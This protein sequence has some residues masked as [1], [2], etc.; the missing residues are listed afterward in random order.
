MNSFLLIILISL[1]SVVIGININLNNKKSSGGNNKID[2]NKLCL[3]KFGE[4][5]YFD[6][7]ENKCKKSSNEEDEEDV[8]EEDQEEPSEGKE[9][10]EDNEEIDQVDEETN[11]FTC[12]GSEDC[13]YQG[14]CID[15]ACVCDTNYTGVDCNIN[16]C[17]G[18]DCV[19][20]YCENG[21]C[22]CF[23]GWNTKMD[24]NDNYEKCTVDVCQNN[25]CGQEDEIKRGNC[26]RAENGRCLCLD[27][28]YG[29]F[30]ENNSCKKLIKNSDNTFTVEDKCLNNSYC[31]PNT[32]TCKCNV[33]IQD[34]QVQ[35]NDQGELIKDTSTFFS[36]PRCKQNLCLVNKNGEMVNK[37]NNGTC[38]IYGDCTCNFGYVDKDG[39][40]C[41]E[42]KCPNCQNG[43]CVKRIINNKVRYMCDCDEGWIKDQQGECTINN[44]L[45]EENGSYVL[46][47]LTSEKYKSKCDRQSSECILDSNKSFVKCECKENYAKSNPD[48]NECDICEGSIQKDS[49][50]NCSVIDCSSGYGEQKYYFDQVT[51]LC[52]ANICA[53]PENCKTA[54]VGTD[55]LYP[56]NSNTAEQCKYNECNDGYNWNYKVCYDENMNI[57]DCSSDSKDSEKFGVCLENKCNCQNGVGASGSECPINGMTKCVSCNSGFYKKYS[58]ETKLQE[59]DFYCD[60]CVDIA[61]VIDGD[62]CKNCNSHGCTSGR[63]SC[64]N[65]GCQCQDKYDGSFCELCKGELEGADCDL[66]KCMPNHSDFLNCTRNNDEATC[67]TDSNYD[68]ECVCNCENN[69]FCDKKTGRCICDS[70]SYFEGMQCEIDQCNESHSEYHDCVNGTCEVDPTNG[71]ASC[72]C[73][74]TNFYGSKCERPIDAN[75]IQDCLDSNYK[76]SQSC[77]N[78]L[79]ESGRINLCKNKGR[80]FVKNKE[81]N[82]YYCELPIKKPVL[83]IVENN[84]NNVLIKISINNSLNFY[85]PSSAEFNIDNLNYE[86]LELNTEHFQTDLSIENFSNN[87]AND[88]ECFYPCGYNNADFCFEKNGLAKKEDSARLCNKNNEIF[89]ACGN[90][91][92]SPKKRAKT[93]ISYECLNKLWNR[94]GCAGVYISSSS[95]T[96]FKNNVSKKNITE[97]I[98]S[99]K[100]IRYNGECGEQGL[101]SDSS[102]DVV[103]IDTT[104]QPL[105]PTVNIVNRISNCNSGERCK[106]IKLSNLKP[107]NK[108]SFRIKYSTKY[109]NYES[110]FSDLLVFRT[111]CRLDIGKANE[112]C[113]NKCNGGMCGPNLY[114]PNV[115]ED[116]RDIS[117]DYGWPYYKRHLQTEDKCGCYEFDVNEKKLLCNRISRNNLYKNFLYHD[118]DCR[119]I[120]SDSECRDDRTGLDD[121]YDRLFVKISDKNEKYTKCTVE[122]NLP[123]K[124]NDRGGIWIESLKSPEIPRPCFKKINRPTI[125]KIDIK[126]KKCILYVEINDLPVPNLLEQFKF[127]YYILVSNT[128][129]IVIGDI[130]KAILANYSDISNESPDPQNKYF[131]L[132]I[133]SLNPRTSYSVK[134]KLYNLA[135]NAYESDY[136]YFTNFVTLCDGDKNYAKCKALN[137]PLLVD[138]PNNIQS[139]IGSKWPFFKI[140]SDDMCDCVNFTDDQRRDYCEGNLAVNEEPNYDQKKFPGFGSYKFFDFKCMKVKTI[141]DCIEESNEKYKQYFENTS[142][143]A[144]ESV[145]KEECQEH[146]NN[147]NTVMNIN[148]NIEINKPPGCIKINNDIYWNSRG[149]QAGTGV[150]S[151]ENKCIQKKLSDIY[152]SLFPMIPDEST[153]ETS[154]RE[155]TRNEKETICNA[156]DDRI[157]WID[158]NNVQNYKCRHTIPQPGLVEVSISHDKAVFLLDISINDNSVNDIDVFYNLYQANNNPIGLKMI[159]SEQISDY[160]QPEVNTE[161]FSNDIKYIQFTIDNLEQLTDYKIEAFVETNISNYNSTVSEKISFT[162]L[163]DADSFTNLS[164]KSTYGPPLSGNN[165]LTVYVNPQD[166]D[167]S[168]SKW[169]YHKINSNLCDCKQYNDEERVELCKNNLT[170]NNQNKFDYIKV[171]V[172]DSNL[173]KLTESECR[174]FHELPNG[175]REKLFLTTSSYDSN[176]GGSNGNPN[177]EAGCVLLDNNLYYN[178]VA[179]SDVSCDSSN[180]FC[181]KK[182]TKKSYLID[183]D[184][185]KSD[186]GLCQNKIVKVG[187]IKNFIVTSLFTNQDVETNPNGTFKQLLN[188]QNKMNTPYRILIKWDI[189]EI[190]TGMTVFIGS[191][192]PISYKIYR[193][194]DNVNYNLIHTINVSDQN[195]TS[196][197]WIDGDQLNYNS[198]EDSS[199]LSE[200]TTYFYKIIPVNS[201]GEYL[202]IDNPIMSAKTM[203]RLKTNSECS[204]EI[205][206]YYQ[207]A[208][209]YLNGSNF[210]GFTSILDMNTNTCISPTSHRESICKKLVKVNPLYS[211]TYDSIRKKCVPAANPVIPGNPNISVTSNNIFSDSIILTLTHPTFKGEPE[212]SHYRLRLKFDIDGRDEYQNLID[213]ITK[214]QLISKSDDSSSQEYHHRGLLPGTTYTYVLEAV[215]LDNDIWSLLPNSQKDPSTN[216]YLGVSN[217][218]QQISI[219]TNYD[220]PRI[221]KS[222]SER[223]STNTKVEFIIDDNFDLD[224]FPIVQKGGLNASLKKT[225]ITKTILDKDERNPKSNSDYSNQESTEFIFE[226]I[227]ELLNKYPGIYFKSIPGNKVKIIDYNISPQT[228]YQYKIEIS[229]NI[230]PDVYSNTNNNIIVTTP[231]KAPIIDIDQRV[232]LENFTGSEFIRV[233]LSDTIKNRFEIDFKIEEFTDPNINHYAFDATSDI[234]TELGITLDQPVVYESIYNQYIN[235]VTYKIFYRKEGSQWLLRE[236]NDYG[237]LITIEN[238]LPN[239]KYQIKII[240]ECEGAVTLQNGL[241]IPV[242]S[243]NNIYYNNNPYYEINVRALTEDD[244]KSKDIYK[245]PQTIFDQDGS[246]FNNV[247]NYLDTSTGICRNRNN[248]YL[249]D[250]CKKNYSSAVNPN[251]IYVTKNIKGL[252]KGTC[253]TQT[254]GSWEVSYDR[255]SEHL[256]KICSLGYNDVI[257]IVCGT[258]KRVIKSWIYNPPKNLGSSGDLDDVPAELFESGTTNF[259]SNSD[260]NFNMTKEN[261]IQ[262]I[263]ECKTKTCELF[264]YEDCSTESCK[265]YCESRPR[266]NWWKGAD[267]DPAKLSSNAS[268][269]S[270]LYSDST[271]VNRCQSM[272]KIDR[273]IITEK[274]NTCSALGCGNKNTS[275]ETIKITCKDGAWDHINL[276]SCKNTTYE[277]INSNGTITNLNFTDNDYVRDENLNDGSPKTRKIYEV[278][279]DI[280]CTNPKSTKERNF[281]WCSWNI[282]DW[283][284]CTWKSTDPQKRDHNNN[285]C[286]ADMKGIKTRVVTCSSTTGSCNTAIEPE[287]EAECDLSLCPIACVTESNWTDIDQ[288][289]DICYR[290]QTVGIREFCD[291]GYKRQKRKINRMHNSAA[292]ETQSCSTTIFKEGSSNFELKWED[293]LLDTDCGSGSCINKTDGSGY[294]CRCNIGYTGDHCKQ[295][296]TGYHDDNGVCRQNVCTCSNG[297]AKTGSLCTNHN[298]NM[299]SSCNTGY[300]K[301]GNNCNINKCKCSNGTGATGSSC[302]KN[303]N[304]KCASCNNG[305]YLN[306]NSCKLKKCTC[307]NGTAATGTSCPTNGSAKCTSCDST[308][309]LDGDGCSKL[310][311]CHS[312]KSGGGQELTDWSNWTAHR[313]HWN[314]G[315]HIRTFNANWAS[316]EA[317]CA[318]ECRKDSRCK[319]FMTWAGKCHLYQGGE[320]SGGCHSSTCYFMDC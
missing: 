227:N 59:E 285:K 263:D 181:I 130:S 120:L 232:E 247:F 37:C 49:E 301:S 44:C 4:E 1:L 199:D 70:L 96:F 16:L 171:S 122:E 172:G 41:I 281:D 99:M 212:F 129:D 210:I 51:N 31:N 174:K 12:S 123:S 295:C 52:K 242:K 304:S 134:I 68:S 272:D 29:E 299:C 164:C 288:P 302:P 217:Q 25:K 267:N 189:P 94:E 151:D 222:I 259:K 176:W 147:L 54:A 27:G 297:N 137:G 61:D 244:C 93:G 229:N 251:L 320:E 39:E 319:K 287:S 312:Q 30:C 34:Y 3:D 86:L 184:L 221:S 133:E 20:G 146:S 75:Y 309:Y 220:A 290:T 106:Y 203:E 36:G 14:R 313:P 22:N 249:S 157:W 165:Y 266:Y 173:N 260:N 163:C 139:K 179:N 286:S 296:S 138:N 207:N 225:K 282:N 23:P 245:Q 112:R 180:K 42:N 117:V 6:K 155:R 149:D 113:R 159:P 10:N 169:P 74:G 105:I 170:I 265:D 128:G 131:K 190:P 144:D 194:I 115:P 276:T 13:N 231:I 104:D 153:K 108:Y 103:S 252:V 110:Q 119:K 82:N 219:T 161:H 152:D 118:N 198:N 69:G 79:N 269:S 292:N 226:N 240:V 24:V 216:S 89:V 314:V 289:G 241:I 65:N 8:K 127:K 253:G 140:N 56:C 307:S 196:F 178:R 223:I 109:E 315:Y 15:Q 92:G 71:S 83:S 76:F 125:V 283:D 250:W 262:K 73:N 175:S 72:N 85:S 271:D 274:L 167:P 33:L 228:T 234:Q 205:S 166:K 160:S 254:D 81:N 224:S 132:E 257:D 258:G 57:V 107:Y 317:Q 148:S 97:I 143:S 248:Y 46:D 136:S 101:L 243:T 17:E 300:Y 35:I 78:S 63:G 168:I 156:Q 279:F 202:E 273:E 310:S 126:A 303:D 284:S 278:E 53:L 214:F 55:P 142:G 318:D 213:P 261:Y 305:Y 280:L 246:A 236:T 62:T 100:Q 201:A 209:D 308:H 2:L 121:Y 268:A 11:N 177:L 294:E 311:R 88:D 187:P 277:F 7:N 90:W 255:D 291:G 191:V 77:F 40:R 64:S 84:G 306:G 186:N 116:K 154:C 238:I 208:P 197:F 162:T 298:T 188:D 60:R 235:G 233:K 48:S 5:Y 111:K 80:N 218:P 230:L 45:K 195:I 114:D 135:N 32:G 239:S 50:G 26:S 67:T 182:V 211:N 124:C 87:N 200:G 98:A 28:W 237:S 9:D 145:T 21:N 316:H 66:N 38:N 102:S 95:P 256:D 91:M 275:K 185:V 270:F 293:C 158:P 47:D 58:D 19:N 215:S 264:L 192:K 43:K 18:I 150:C 206:D 193:S 183:E 141:N 204:N